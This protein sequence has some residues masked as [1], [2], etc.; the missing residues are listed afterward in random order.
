MTNA[1][2][3][4]SI[5]PDSIQTNLR[6]RSRRRFVCGSL[7]PGGRMR[8]WSRGIF[9]NMMEWIA[10]SC[11][12]LALISVIRQ[13][14][15][16]K[17]PANIRYG[18][19]LIVLVRLLVPVSLTGS[20]IS[21]L[22]LFSN[23]LQNIQT[24]NDKQ[25]M[26]PP[27]AFYGDN[28]QT[29]GTG[30]SQNQTANVSDTNPG[31]VEPGTA[32]AADSIWR[33]ALTGI[34][35]TGM[36]V[37]GLALAGSN[38]TFM[39]KLRRSR[40]LI[41]PQEIRTLEYGS[42]M[43][44]HISVYTS[45]LVSTPCLFGL[46]RPAI[47]IRPEDRYNTADLPYILK[48]EY[49]HYR[50][51]DHIWAF[52]RGICLIIHWYNP[53]VWAGAYWNRQDGELACDASVLA[54][55]EDANRLAYGRLLIDLT[56]GNHPYGEILCC[57]TTMSGGKKNL[58]ERIR[59]IAEHP[60]LFLIPTTIAL[61]LCL[62][63]SLVTFTATTE[64][65]PPENKTA[66]NDNSEDFESAERL[67][68]IMFADV[69]HDGAE[70]AI[71]TTVKFFAEEE[72]SL[73]IDA[74]LQSF[75]TE[76]V[77]RVYDGNTFFQRYSDD[78]EKWTRLALEGTLTNSI[79]Y[80]RNQEAIWERALGNPHVSNGLVFLTWQNGEA[81]L[82]DCSAWVG[83]GVGA[84]S[85]EVFSLNAAGNINEKDN[86]HMSF[87]LNNFAQDKWEDIFPI[88][89]MLAF[90]EQIT[91]WLE[92]SVAVAVMDV[93]YEPLVNRPGQNDTIEPL[94]IWRGFLGESPAG[95][96]DLKNKLEQILQELMA[97]DEEMIN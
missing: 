57:A 67:V 14:F 6:L 41:P 27:G 29:K 66:E 39:R 83:Q 7:M 40:Q 19:W 70:D 10:A 93:G 74:L 46:F 34:W 96:E 4:Y 13:I 11:I 44:E 86:G 89:D 8:N 12:L 1:E 45:K 51:L 38:L 65:K 54:G 35:I 76:T 33:T 53:L 31:S 22:N 36:A 90:T 30:G 88:P 20:D 43:A 97:E 85:Y 59:R 60:R 82:L 71:V 48:H 21:V 77:I 95:M 28:M 52:F 78:K 15:K 94:A 61:A 3:E 63:V 69:T 64:N 42:A 68:N 73:S 9:M 72:S 37:C 62:A 79:E 58:K 75:S 26:S 55:M 80:P 49:T 23:D 17:L 2:L 18:I 87:A 5:R 84:F 47:Y 32:N 91:P 16:E 24:Q 50:H 92:E 81:Y 25:M 56:K